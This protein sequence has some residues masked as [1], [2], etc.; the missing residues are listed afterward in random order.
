MACLIVILDPNTR[1]VQR[2]TQEEANIQDKT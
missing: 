2:I 1:C